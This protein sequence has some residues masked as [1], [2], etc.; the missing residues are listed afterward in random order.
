MA[1][2]INRNLREYQALKDM[3][4]IPE[5]VLDFYCSQF[6]EKYDRFPELDELP[7]VNSE[8][9]LKQAIKI[10]PIGDIEFADNAAIEENIGV[11]PEEASA[12]INSIHKDLEV[13]V[14]KTSD[15]HS[16]VEVRHRPSIFEDGT[17]N[18]DGNFEATKENQ[19]IILRQSLDRMR[20]LYGIDIVE[21][22]TAELKESGIFEQIP[23][24]EIARAFIYNG[25]IYV[26]SDLADL[27]APVHEM[28]HIFLGAM[29]YTNP[30][31][32]QKIIESVARFSSVEQIAKLYPNRTTGDLLEEVLV[33]EMADMLTG[34]PS[35]LNYLPVKD[36]NLMMYEIQRNLDTMLMGNISVKSFGVEELANSTILELAGKTQSPEFNESSISV[37]DLSDMHRRTA[38]FK[39]KLM[40][41]GELEEI[42][43]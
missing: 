40:E 7:N 19:R 13:K 24:A 43:E 35:E 3:S 5:I 10:Q 30:V 21:A 39:Q 16:M 11:P 36:L 2:C 28:L 32:Y 9:Y 6:L 1:V 31:A 17:E 4:G 12:K 18:V 42:C 26:N 37:M 33:T 14:I 29:R 22:S 15:E 38:N 23:D 25:E 41:S 34:K 20:T 8:G 27:D